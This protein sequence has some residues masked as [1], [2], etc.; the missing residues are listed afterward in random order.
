MARSLAHRRRGLNRHR[1]Q[2]GAQTLDMESV[3]QFALGACIG[4]VTI[5]RRVGMRKAAIL[6]GIAA[7]LPDLDVF[8]P[9]ADPV[10]SFVHH[11]AATHSLVMHAA[12]TPVLGEALRLTDRRLRAARLASYA[13]VF[14]CLSTH[15]L[16]DYFTVYGT[17]LFWPIWREPLAISSIFVIDPLYTLP[18]LIATVWA[19]FVGDWSPRLA[20]VTTGAFVLSSLYL[21]WTMVAQQIALSRAQAWLAGA[22]VKA[23]QILAQPTPLNSLFWRVI[24]IDGPRYFNVYVPVLGGQSAVSAYVHRRHPEL[25]ECLNGKGRVATLTAFSHGFF[26]YDMEGAILMWSDLRMGMSPGYSFRFAVAERQ[27]DGLKPVAPRRMRGQRVRE[28][29]FEWLFAGMRGERAVRLAE[30]EQAVPDRSR[31]AA[32]PLPALA[33]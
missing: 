26:R 14:L 29:D 27:G 25:G 4:V 11:R 16:L 18:L 2:A 3:T 15:A 1:A 17:Q 19:L 8:W 32:T 10:D 33:C 24:A 12:A 21:G 9:Y 28:G 6:G 30:A 23:Q 22:G 7:T 20:R 5:G 13:A 31:L